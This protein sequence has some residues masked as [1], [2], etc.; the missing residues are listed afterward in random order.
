MAFR[1]K[2][3]PRRVPLLK[4]ALGSGGYQPGGAIFK[5][6]TTV[7]ARDAFTVRGNSRHWGQLQ[8]KKKGPLPVGGKLE[9]NGQDVKKGNQILK[10]TTNKVSKDRT[11]SRTKGT[12]LKIFGEQGGVRL[13]ELTWRRP[14]ECA[15]GRNVYIGLLS[16]PLGGG[17]HRPGIQTI[18]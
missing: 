9:G 15:K 13:P 18:F 1:K 14:S 6:P 3:T 17:G 11:K 10:E 7:R 8:Q 12:G 16:Q 4:G 2:R 5:H